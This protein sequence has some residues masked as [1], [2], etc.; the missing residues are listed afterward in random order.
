M[1]I[2]KLAL[3]YKLSRRIALLQA[4]RWNFGEILTYTGHEL[5]QKKYLLIQSITEFVARESAS[6]LSAPP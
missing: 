1:K 6:H 4:K 5:K 2:A 3:S